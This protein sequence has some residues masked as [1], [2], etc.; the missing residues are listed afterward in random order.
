[1]PP[2]LLAEIADLI[3][4]RT[5]VA[6]DGPSGSLCSACAT[7]LA[8]DLVRFAGPR[9]VWP[10][11]TPA[12][13][14][15]CWAVGPYDG[16]LAAMVRAFKD[17]DR[18]DLGAVLG[19]LL[20]ES[21][22][23]VPGVAADPACWVVPAPGSRAAQR[24]RGRR[25]L[26]ETARTAAAALPEPLTVA[27]VLRHARRV[28]DQAGLD[29]SGRQANLAGAVSTRRGGGP[30]RG[31]RVVLVD[32]VVTSGAT[33]AECAR[34]LEAAGA[35]VLGAAVVCATQRTGD[36]STTASG[37]SRGRFVPPLSP[38]GQVG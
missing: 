34:V 1:M 38:S 7:T 8:V 29:A 17:G 11:P 3:L 32:D 22:A 14:P 26:V 2:A 5:C 4:P 24:A 19:L 6:C 37:T 15:A 25:P 28:K 23:A 27:P 30:L 20:A 21:V 13:F 31:R 36:R 33:L 35:L 16:P 12:G 10:T 9:P 18:R